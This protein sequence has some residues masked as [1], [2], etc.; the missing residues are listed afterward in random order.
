MWMHWILCPA[1]SCAT[2]AACAA[3]R[4]SQRLQE[5]AGLLSSTIHQLLQYKLAGSGLDA[6]S[7]RDLVQGVSGHDRESCI[8]G[9]R[10]WRECL[11]QE[12][13]QRCHEIT[14]V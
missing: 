2:A 10:L 4:A 8:E 9:G 3:G 1:R 7:N 14:R 11:A 12:Q 5:M 13:T 6:L